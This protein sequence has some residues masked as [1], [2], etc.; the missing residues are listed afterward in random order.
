MSKA[1]AEPQFANLERSCAEVGY[2]SK[3]LT[4]QKDTESE[5]A[6]PQ[7]NDAWSVVT[8]YTNRLKALGGRIE[9]NRAEEW[10]DLFNLTERVLSELCSNKAVADHDLTEPLLNRIFLARNLE[11]LSH[12][13]EKFTEHVAEIADVMAKE[14]V[15]GAAGQSRANSIAKSSGTDAAVEKAGNDCKPANERIHLRL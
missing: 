11:E 3:R 12:G 1:G 4:E 10:K 14:K 7:W 2:G 13:F 5:V 6:R 9:Q 8:A 15:P